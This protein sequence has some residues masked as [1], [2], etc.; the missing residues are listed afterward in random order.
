MIRLDRAL[1]REEIGAG[2]L[3]GLAV[4]GTTQV[5][6]ADD[7]GN[8]VSLTQTLGATFGGG[9]AVPGFGFAFNNLLN[10]YEFRDPR[11]WA[12]ISPLQ[13]NH[14]CMA[15]SIVLRSGTPFLVV[16]G[17][18]SARIAPSIVELLLRLTDGRRSLRD[19]M[20]APR[21][22]WGGNA[23][24]QI[25]LEIVG[26][27]TV[28]LADMLRERGFLAQTRLTYPA[29]T[30]HVTDF[31]GVNAILIDP[32]TGLFTGLGDPRRQGVAM[33]PQAGGETLAQEYAPPEC[34]APPGGGVPEPQAPQRRY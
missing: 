24:E 1:T 25:Y 17:A 2:S 33:E 21:A 23:D 31:G 29:S 9:V 14:H 8:L 11:A 27:T 7:D 6:A 4:E 16:G 22:L 26:T 12:F 13:P 5:S 32:V 19:A 10:G 30:L 15:P 3:S 34:L 28:Q 20:A 18:G